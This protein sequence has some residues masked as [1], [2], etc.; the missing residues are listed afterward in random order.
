MPKKAKTEALRTA[1]LAKLKDNEVFFIKGL[2]PDKPSTKAAS[3]ALA[4]LQIKGSTLVVLPGHDPVLYKSF[5]NISRVM[6]IP[7]GDVNSY[8]LLRNRNTVLLGDA[9]D[10]MKERLGNG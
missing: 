4:K 9:F 3:A 6:V 8:H 7:A 5:R 10:R 1:L 2:A